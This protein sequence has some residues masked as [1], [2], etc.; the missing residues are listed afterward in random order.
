MFELATYLEAV[1]S[2][3]VSANSNCELHFEGV[4]G[5]R[6]SADRAISLALIVNELMTNA[7]K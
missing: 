5:I 1:C 3:A 6:L 4:D 7:V 2:D